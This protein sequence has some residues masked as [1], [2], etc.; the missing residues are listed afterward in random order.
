MGA[1]IARLTG[2]HGV[3]PATRS[4]R[5]SLRLRLLIAL[6]VLAALPFSGREARAETLFEAMG[7]AYLNNPTLRA[8]RAKL[9]AIDERVP[10]ALA[11]MRP[12]FSIVTSTQK[13]L[14]GSTD[15]TPGGRSKTASIEVTQ[16]LYKGG[17]IQSK[18]SSAHNLVLAGRAALLSVEQTVLLSAATAFIDVIRDQYILELYTTY[19]KV[20]T[21]Q[22][23][24]ERRRLRA[25]ESTRTDVSQAEVRLAQAIAD[26]IQAEA[27]LRSSISTYIQVIGSEPGKLAMPKVSVSI[28][29]S[30]D[31]VTEAARTNNPDVIA[32][33]YSESSARNDVEAI[34][35]KLLPLVEAVG[36]VSRTWYNNT[37]YGTQRTTTGMLRMTVPLDNGAVAAQA[38]GARQTVSQMM[39][40]IEAAQ[41]T[42]VDKAMRSWSSFKAV[43]A[44]ILAREAMVRSIDDTVRNLRTEVNIGTRTVTDLLNTEQEALSARI[45]LVGVRHDSV[46]MSFTLLSAIGQL[47]AQTLKLPV[48]YYDYQAHYQQVRNKVWG[49]SLEKDPK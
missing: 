28:P 27:T 11:D 24:H 42:A 45:S 8:E 38:R 26:R 15:S 6:S 13:P 25:G 17:Q 43:Q 12:S 30:L 48:E 14:G 49:V 22:L 34:D 35:G 40:Q 18:I 16:P 10:E 31:D 29:E 9:R 4:P 20:L 2:R 7:Q 32:A 46:L 47:T 19:Q 33:Q 5:G 1:L 36:T 41:R 37:E 21:D 44:Q 39:M 23:D 3:R